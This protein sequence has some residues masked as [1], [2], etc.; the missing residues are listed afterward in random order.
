MVKCI[1]CQVSSQLNTLYM[2]FLKRN[3]GYNGKVSLYG[4]SLGSVLSYDI[5]C[6]QESLT[7]P[8]PMDSV[9]FEA[10]DGQGDVVNGTHEQVQSA[11]QPDRGDRNMCRHVSFSDEIVTHDPE[12]E[13]GK[14]SRV[15]ETELEGELGGKTVS[16]VV[17][18][19][20]KLIS[21]LEEEVR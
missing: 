11:S 13:N 16:N 10:V 3:P 8:F 18:D 20:D 21:S 7:S 6:H 4:H 15:L 12:M 5:L 2:K 19:K 17:V 14:T 9:T 1:Y